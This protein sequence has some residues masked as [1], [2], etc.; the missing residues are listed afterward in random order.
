[1]MAS[2]VGG[3]QVIGARCGSMKDQRV[4]WLKACAVRFLVQEM[5]HLLG[6]ELD[7]YLVRRIASFQIVRVEIGSEINYQAVVIVEIDN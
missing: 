2:P 1:M 3:S 6:S 7:G 5:E 4:V